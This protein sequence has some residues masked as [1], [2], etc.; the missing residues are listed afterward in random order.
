[1][2][3]NPL[4]T[5]ALA[6]FVFL[7][8]WVGTLYERILP[9]FQESSEPPPVTEDIPQETETP[10]PP[11]PAPSPSP[12]PAPFSVPPQITW[13]NRN[14]NQVVFTFDAGSGTNSFWP[15]INAFE[16]RGLKTTFFL[17]G[18]WAETNPT[19]VQTIAQKG[20]EFFNHTYSHPRLTQISDQAIIDELQKTDEI[21]FNLTGRHTQPYFRPPYKAVDSRVLEVAARQGYQSALWTIDAL[22]WKEGLGPMPEDVK[23]QILN[24]LAP[25]TIYLMHIGDNYTGV[26]LD[27]VLGEIINRGYTIVPLSEG[28]E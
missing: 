14:K 4:V 2:I 9:A 22:D 24:N 15:I 1:M 8:A 12:A 27:E 10:P 17:T 18:R 16:A 7:S 20:H 13:A 26:V 19:L 6:I 11:A 28:V 3:N 21:I 23:N 25:G 5:L